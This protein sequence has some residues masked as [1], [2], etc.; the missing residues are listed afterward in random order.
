MRPRHDG[1]PDQAVIVFRTDDLFWPLH[2]AVKWIA[3]KGESGLPPPDEAF[4]RAVLELLP[5]LDQEIRVQGISAAL[6]V[7]HLASS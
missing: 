1:K 5:A 4:D 7:Q 6:E 2:A 3:L